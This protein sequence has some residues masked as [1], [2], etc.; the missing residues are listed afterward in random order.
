MLEANGEN[1][2]NDLV[3]NIDL[4]GTIMTQLDEPGHI[5]TSG[6]KSYREH[7]QDFKHVLRGG[8]GSDVDPLL[9]TISYS[10]NRS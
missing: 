8:G 2:G 5:P 7:I 1:E 10:L 4:E 9:I 3:P 6:E